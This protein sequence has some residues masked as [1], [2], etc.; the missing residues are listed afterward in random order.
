MYTKSQCLL[1][2]LYYSLICHKN[3]KGTPKALHLMGHGF[4]TEGHAV[5]IKASQGDPRHNK[6]YR[7]N[8]SMLVRYHKGT[9]EETSVIIDVGKT[10]RESIVRWFPQ[11]NV[12]AVDAIILT[13]GHADA[14]FGLDDIR[15]VQASGSMPVYL[16]DE[17]LQ[18]VQRTFG[19]LFPTPPK[20]GE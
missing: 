13:H 11:H 8:P 15:G 12:T 7:C 17:C 18:T 10:F 14:I 5:S 6:D 1:I 4:G 16:S 2:F 20:P 19:Y 9:P 3:F